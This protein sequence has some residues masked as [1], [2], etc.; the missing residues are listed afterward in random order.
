MGIYTMSR[1]CPGAPQDTD[2]VLS[3]GGEQHQGHHQFIFPGYF[4]RLCQVGRDC[5]SPADLQAVPKAASVNPHHLSTRHFPNHSNF[6][7]IHCLA[8]DPKGVPRA[9]QE[10]AWDKQG[11]VNQ[12]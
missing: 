10:P 2:V 1:E 8:L 5:T 3:A 9:V 6:C 12:V 11:P 4:L 7:K